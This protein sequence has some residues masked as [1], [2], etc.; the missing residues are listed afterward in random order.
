M[1]NVIAS[2]LLPR[3]AIAIL[4]AFHL[5]KW[6]CYVVSM[7]FGPFS[8]QRSVFSVQHTDTGDAILETGRGHFAC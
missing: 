8:V 2:A 7:E 4:V 5:P 3:I 1:Y 6:K